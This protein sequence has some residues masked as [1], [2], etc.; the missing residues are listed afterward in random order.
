MTP[1]KNN[2]D[3]ISVKD[4]L[5]K[6]RLAAGHVK[7]KWLIILTIGALG[8][9]L[10]LVY[11]IIK[12][13]LYT[14]SSTFV[15][16]EG[17]KGGG[18]SQYAGLASIAGID[19]GGGGSGSIF[20]E[21]NILELYK[22]R[23]MIEK[24]LLSESI[25]NGKRQLL[26][27]RYIEFNNLR[28]AWKK[29][30]KINDISFYGDPNGFNRTQDSIISALVILFNKQSLTVIKPDKK[31]SIIR[32]D[33]V[34]TDELF[35]KNFNLKLVQTVN[36]FYL[37]TKTKKSSQNISILKH[38]ADSVRNV[39]NSSI[40][41]VASAIDAS[42]NANPSLQILKTASQRKQVD[43]QA[44]TAIYSEII[45]NLELSKISL[46]QETP[47]IQTIDLPVLPLQVVKI[48]KITAAI[49]GFF[50][51]LFFTMVILV[52]KKLI[53]SLQIINHTNSA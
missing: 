16:D 31:I 32:V 19:L 30:D 39:L 10:G 53:D 6:L 46:R 28:A 48:G 22:S 45:K 23:A 20:Q 12:K 38:Q 29:K 41:G 26:I 43:V 3:E 4:F 5:G 34:S 36:D 15:L 47:L 35:A 33:V 13:P 14:A 42:P 37:Q 9:T 24:A 52:G 11:S 2:P 21:D 49:I 27:D 50:L 1:T 18:L 7:S 44:S 8:S 25:F 17:S 51:G 40:S